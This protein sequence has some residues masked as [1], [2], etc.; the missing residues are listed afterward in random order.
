MVITE[1]FPPIRDRITGR[2]E[3]IEAVHVPVEPAVHVDVQAAPHDDLGGHRSVVRHTVVALFV[4]AV[5]GS[6]AV[7][8]VVGFVDFRCHTDSVVAVRGVVHD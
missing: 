1:R 8:P 2:Q 7:H 6:V 4:A 5:L 3:V